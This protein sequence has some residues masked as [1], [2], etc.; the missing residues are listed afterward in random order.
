MAMENPPLSSL[1]FPAQL[2]QLV[3]GF[4]SCDWLLEGKPIGVMKWGWLSHTNISKCFFCFF[5]FCFAGSAPS[6]AKAPSSASAAPFLSLSVD[7]FFVKQWQ[8][9]FLSPLAL[10]QLCIIFSLGSVFWGCIW[11][12]TSFWGC[13][14]GCFWWGCLSSWCCFWGWRGPGW[15]WHHIW[16]PALVSLA[17]V[18]L[19]HQPTEV[20]RR[21]AAAH[22]FTLWPKAALDLLGHNLSSLWKH[23]GQQLMTAPFSRTPCIHV[24]RWAWQRCSPSLS[25][26][27]SPS[28]WARHV[29]RPPPHCHHPPAPWLQLSG[30][31]SG[32]CGRIWCPSGSW[33]LAFFLSRPSW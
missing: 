1:I 30:H 2:S 14:W 11:L 12:W 4:S 7:S 32:A 9:Q 23:A 20:A 33:A 27:P 15:W 6:S 13:Y 22:S 19:L 28:R 31:L 8:L 17:A 18:P 5:F 24:L 25:S 16:G 10:G 26:L 3:R 29:Q 21:K